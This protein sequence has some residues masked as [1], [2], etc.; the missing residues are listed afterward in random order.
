MTSKGTGWTPQQEPPVLH[1]FEIPE[2]IYEQK[3]NPVTQK[4][5]AVFS[6]VGKRWIEGKSLIERIIDEEEEE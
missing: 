6:E 2:G 1:R 3:Y 5:E 4:V